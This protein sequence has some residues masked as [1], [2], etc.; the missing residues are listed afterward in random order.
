[1][2]CSWANMAAR[3]C[4]Y[5][6][7]SCR[8]LLIK[9]TCWLK[10]TS[11]KCPGVRNGLVRLQLLSSAG[12]CKKTKKKSTKNLIKG[13][14][15]LAAVSCAMHYSLGAWMRIRAVKPTRPPAMERKMVI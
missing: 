12:Y 9:W 1:M 4:N 6:I 10:V 2:L 3:N 5:S 15:E 7:S 11:E 8:C 14:G 13:L